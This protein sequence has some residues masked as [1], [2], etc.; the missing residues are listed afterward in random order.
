MSQIKELAHAMT[1]ALA[2]LGRWVYIHDLLPK[3]R[4]IVHWIR[5]EKAPLAH[6]QNFIGIVKAPPEFPRIELY[7]LALKQILMRLADEQNT[8]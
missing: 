4:Q 6:P 8:S 1:S 3:R 5:I 2:P 7:G